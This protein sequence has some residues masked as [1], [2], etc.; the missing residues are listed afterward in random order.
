M[1]H[2]ELI[3][4]LERRKVVFQD[5]SGFKGMV[6]GIAEDRRIVC[7]QSRKSDG[8]HGISFWIYGDEFDWY[9][10]LWSGVYF[11]SRVP[12][13]IPDVAADLLA[14]RSFASV[15]PPA[16]LPDAF[17]QEYGLERVEE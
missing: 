9:I 2:D 12:D 10:G 16:D 3:T 15:R 17:C 13:R 6:T 4:E 11:R 7:A 8:L 5:Q 14:G 1:K